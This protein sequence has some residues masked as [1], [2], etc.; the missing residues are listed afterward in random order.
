MFPS[1][2]F[3]AWK[4]RYPTLPGQE[5][6]LLK[7]LQIFR[8][9]YH[10]VAMCPQSVEDLIHNVTE[11]SRVQIFSQHAEEEPVADAT[12]TVHLRNRIALQVPKTFTQNVSSQ[13]RASYYA[14]HEYEPR[15]SQA[16]EN[17]EPEPEERVE[18]PVQGVQWQDAHG[19]IAMQSPRGA[20]LVESALHHFRKHVRRGVDTALLIGCHKAD[21]PGTVGPEI[22]A[23]EWIHEEHLTCKK[24]KTTV[25][26]RDPS[27]R[28]ELWSRGEVVQTDTNKKER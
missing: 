2:D 24:Y 26:L 10:A 6:K 17:D 21:E 8:Y 14:D 5:Q 16:E 19:V 3:I 28:A 11:N 20:V 12:M 25:H 7:G 27:E 23:Q 4:V 13:F 15:W 22:L 9:L 1:E 18:P